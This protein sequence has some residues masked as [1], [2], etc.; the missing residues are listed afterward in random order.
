MRLYELRIKE[1]GHWERMTLHAAVVLYDLSPED[2][3]ALAE[4]VLAQTFE[5]AVGTWTRLK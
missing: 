2:L 5:A 1:T 4:L 3:D